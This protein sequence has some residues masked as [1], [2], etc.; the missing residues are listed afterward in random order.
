MLYRIDPLWIAHWGAFPTLCVGPP[1]PPLRGGFQHLQAN[2][3]SWVN[4][5]VRSTDGIDQMFFQR[6]VGPWKTPFACVS[7]SELNARLSGG[8]VTLPTDS[9]CPTRLAARRGAGSLRPSAL[10]SPTLRQ[11]ARR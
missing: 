2:S 7:L 5:R 3:G 9:V 6:G 8:L 4:V 1:T 10:A 11:P